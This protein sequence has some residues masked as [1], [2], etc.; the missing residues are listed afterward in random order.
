M[1]P[2]G[3]YPGLN[4]LQSCAST[5]LLFFK[6]CEQSLPKSVIRKTLFILLQLVD[7]PFLT[8]Q[9]GRTL[10]T[11]LTVTQVAIQTTELHQCLKTK[12]FTTEYI[13]R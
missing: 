8:E 11:P 3:K 12:N 4:S 7:L 10:Q 2:R 9:D 6:P 1:V 13:H 5:S